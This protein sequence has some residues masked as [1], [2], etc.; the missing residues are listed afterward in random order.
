MAHFLVRM[1]LRMA[2]RSF[3][4]RYGAEI[5]AVHARRRREGAGGFRYT[6]RELMG[7]L[8]VV[9]QLRLGTGP[10]AGEREAR[11][12]G[13]TMLE[14]VRQDV[15]FAVR[16]LRRSPGFSLAVVAVL[17]VGI[18]AN[19]AIF[20]AANA[21]LFRELPFRDANRLVMLYETNPEFGWTRASAAPANVLDWQDQ[22]DAFEDVAS[23]STFVGQ[24][25]YFRD[26]EPGLLGAV[27]VSGNFFSVLGVEPVV[28]RMFRPEETWSPDDGVA[29]LSHHF[30]VTAF[31][32]DPG[33]VGRR[34]DLGSSSLEIV[35]VA[36]SGFAFPAP[37]SDVW[38]PWGWDPATREATWFRRAHWVRPVARLRPEVSV[39]EADAALQVVVKRLQD[40]YPE[41][42]R[43]MGAGLTPMRDFLTADVRRPLQILMGAVV[44]LL[45]LACTNVANLMLVRAADRTREVALRFAL[46][47]GRRRV[48]RQ[49][50]TE[51]L[52][53][54][55]VG[56]VV[57]LALGWW[58][59][60]ALE[61]QQPMGIRGATGL[62]LDGRVVL[63]TAVVSVASGLLF[64]LAP[65]VQVSR[66]NTQAGLRGGGRSMSAGR[67]QRRAAG[68][69]VAAEL[70]LAVLVVVGAGLMV[71]TFWHLRHVDPG[72]EPQGVL[73]VLFSVPS[74]RYENRDQVLAFQD[75][76]ERRLRAR[77]GIEDV[78]TV[79]QLPLSGPGW[80][81]QFQAEGWPPDRV[82]FEILHRRVD[83][84]YFTTV[85]TPLLR[86][87]LFGPD[88]GPEAPLVVVV[89]ETFA[90]EHFPGEDPIGQKIAYDR[91][92]TPESNWYEIVGIVGDQLQEDP[93]LPP[94]AEVFEN[95]RQDWSRRVWFV[96]R[97]QGA[98]E[99]VLPVVKEVLH[100]MD[101]LIPVV[102]ARPLDDVWRASMDDQR[103]VLTLFVAFGSMALL[104]ASVGVFGVT[105]QAARR[106]TREFGIRMAL[107]AEGTSV[108]SLVVRQTLGVAAVGVAVG[109][110]AAYWASRAMASLLT[111]VAPGDPATL[112]VVAALLALVACLASWLPARRA[113]AVDPVNSLRAE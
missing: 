87:R 30:W 35:G 66:G 50:L 64:G 39:R 108:V 25:T 106:R 107:G 81:S 53:L 46:G 3:Q 61:A 99:S 94:R 6:L 82:G 13:A 84:G 109:S 14:T 85:R 52:V 86:G 68:M 36:P 1:V 40:A 80:S 49:L 19:T 73:A 79:D 97:S 91:A 28:G 72:F 89:N 22:V 69:L 21:Y 37:E 105:A 100:E 41:T 76:V 93:S 63:F 67:G 110:V 74:A 27:N 70:A 78:G 77:P 20:S 104:L 33:V 4:D 83:P 54:A 11:G 59:I 88:D 9:V 29:V 56:G 15:R 2:P 23:Y 90:R 5:L 42:N 95:R 101:P 31:G 24:V 57:G 55:L 71:R 96:V 18:G 113:A 12:G 26:G 58:G 34:I 17:A 98:P 112:G 43:V 75:D 8:W 7:L 10:G 47:A 60:Q 32:A 92:A 102:T 44:L 111:G 38:T 16:T 51:G 45:L 103:F 48:A 62:A 65:V